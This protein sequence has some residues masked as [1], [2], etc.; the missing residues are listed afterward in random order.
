MEHELVVERH[1]S[2]VQKHLK[3]QLD[4]RMQLDPQHYY[5]LYLICICKFV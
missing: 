4:N 1:L 3:F 5:Y 2:A